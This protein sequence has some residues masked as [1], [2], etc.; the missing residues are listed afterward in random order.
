MSYSGFL[1]D[2][3]YTRRSQNENVTGNWTFEHNIT[4]KEVIRGTA[5]STYYGDLAE[6]YFHS[7][8]E[9]IPLG[10]IVKFGGEKEITKTKPNDRHFFGIVSSKPGIELNKK[11]DDNSIPVAL[12]GKVPCRVSGKI[13]KFDKLTTSKYNGV[14]KRKTFLD[15]LLFKPT[16]GIALENKSEKTEKL[17]EI[18]MHTHI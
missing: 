16:I 1:S 18:F 9:Q 13:N 12:C 3:E 10:T 7:P 6:Y 15:M 8:M 5:I 14:A 2:P 17:I 11:Y 4:C